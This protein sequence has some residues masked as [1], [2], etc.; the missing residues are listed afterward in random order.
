MQR[1]RR[2]GVNLFCEVPE[3]IGAMVDRTEE[4]VTCLHALV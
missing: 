1:L 3:Q 4:S 2:D